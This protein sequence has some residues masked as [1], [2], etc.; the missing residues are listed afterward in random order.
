MRYT[1]GGEEGREANGS[2]ACKG[3]D[4]AGEVITPEEGTAGRI[5]SGA[6]A[7]FTIW[8][9]LASDMVVEETTSWWVKIKVF[10]DQRNPV[11][12]FI[13]DEDAAR[14]S[15]LLTLMQ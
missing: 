15:V 12:L 3:E 8:S 5:L 11:A 1:C 13:A 4:R 2:D 14:I 9:N 7:P 6:G 10:A